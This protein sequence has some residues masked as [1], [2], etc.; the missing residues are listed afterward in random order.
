MMSDRFFV[1]LTLYKSNKCAE[2]L[3]NNLMMNNVDNVAHTAHECFTV[4]TIQ[5]TIHLYMQQ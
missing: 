3:K 4:H 5:E 2:I 1:I